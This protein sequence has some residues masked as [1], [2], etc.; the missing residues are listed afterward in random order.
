[1]KKKTP[2]HRIVENSELGKGVVLSAQE[3]WDLTMD[4]ADY[5]RR[6]AGPRIVG[7]QGS[8]VR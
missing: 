5:D 6:R 2:Y 7:G 4:D 8:Q 1:M 3:V